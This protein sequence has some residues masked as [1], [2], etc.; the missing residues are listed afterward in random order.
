MESG[1][2][3]TNE[4]RVW[5]CVCVGM[6]VYAYCMVTYVVGYGSGNPGILWNV[7]CVLEQQRNF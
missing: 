3:G 7:K 6:P 4:V 2:N 1:S 5:V